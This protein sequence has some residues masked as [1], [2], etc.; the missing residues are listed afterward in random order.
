MPASKGAAAARAATLRTFG[1]QLS[2]LHRAY[3]AAADKA[4]NH[5]GLSSAMAW[6]LLTIGRQGDAVRP[7]VLAELLGI[8]GASLARQL[9]QLEAAGLIERRDDA[10]DRRAKTLHL[11]ADGSAACAR[12]E[13]A[14]AAL[15]TSLFDGIADDDID[16]CLRVFSTLGERL[17]RPVPVRL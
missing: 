8:E 13:K 6:P 12:I 16:A 9:D 14:L 15:R 5:I 2:V 3:R 17:G 11:T 7:G 4:V 10:A 1:S